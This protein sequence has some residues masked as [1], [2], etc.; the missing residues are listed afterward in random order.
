MADFAALQK[1]NTKNADLSLK[2]SARVCHMSL[3]HADRAEKV[4]S[5]MILF[6]RREVIWVV[7]SKMTA[8]Q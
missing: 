3:E 1:L 5:L 7:C 8:N 6:R 2:D 4:C